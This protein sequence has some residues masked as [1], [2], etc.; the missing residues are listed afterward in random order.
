[1]IF[2]HLTSHT[3]NNTNF[4]DFG[5]EAG[6][7][8]LMVERGSFGY[9]PLSTPIQFFERHQDQLFVSQ[10]CLLGWFI[11]MMLIPALFFHGVL[12]FITC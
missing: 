2:N 3:V 10:L 11:M 7:T 1:M 9:L 6:D 4:F 5:V 8:Q 12:I